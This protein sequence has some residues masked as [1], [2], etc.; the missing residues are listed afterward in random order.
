MKPDCSDI[1][2]DLYASLLDGAG[3]LASLRSLASRVG[4]SSHAV[5]TIRYRDGRPTGS[6]SAGHGGIAGTAMAEYA[7]YWVRHDPWARAGAA[8]EPGV[9]DVSRVIAPEELRRSRFWNEWGRP[10]DA[11]FHAIG[12][13]L[14]REGTSLAG[15]F[16]HRRYAEA[17]FEP[18][19]VALLEAMFPHLRRVFAADAQ[20][21]A[22]RDTPGPALGAGLDAL[23]EGVAILNEARN[24]VFANAALRRMAAEADGLALAPDGLDVPYPAVRVALSRA[25]TAALAAAAGQVG[26]LPA[27]GSLALPRRSGRSPWFVRAV[28]VVRAEVAE[29]PSGFRGAMLLVGDPARRARPS[30]ALLA[31]LYG[32]TQAEASL[33]A[34]L[35]AGRSPA[36]HAKRRKIGTETARSHLAAIR[37]KTGCRR[38]SELS[39]LFARLPG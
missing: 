24:L 30:A 32:L 2:T 16:F 39:A 1:A 12:I 29:I 5:H 27:A 13:P 20:L 21:T 4:A 38:Q 33:A 17:P 25:V 28:P 7:R 18:D 8:M 6:E 19:R 22:P 9:H 26:L 3:L 15:V 35:A 37:R 11:A 10:N 14:R 34:S 36:E 23:E 31:R